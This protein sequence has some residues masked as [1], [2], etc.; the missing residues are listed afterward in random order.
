MN[1]NN[2]N[3]LLIPIHIDALAVGKKQP[4]NKR[5]KWTRLGADFSRV[6]APDGG[7]NYLLAGDTL[8]SLDDSRPT[9][10]T[11]VHLHFKLPKAFLHGKHD[12]DGE[13]E[14]PQI[15]N[16]WLIQRFSN[17]SSAYDAWLVKSDKLVENDRSQATPW[18]IFPSDSET[19]LEVKHIGENK[20]LTDKLNE[21]QDEAAEVKLTAIGQGDP[22]FSAHYPA[23]RSVLGFY[24]PLT[25]VSD[26][27]ELNYLVTGWFSAA[28]DDPLYLSSDDVDN[29]SIDVFKQ[30]IEENQIELIGESDSIPTR[31]LCHGLVRKLKW[32]G[33]SYNYFESDKPQAVFP[34]NSDHYAKQ[35]Q[36]AIGNNNIEALVSL[37]KMKC[38]DE[39]MLQ[40]STKENPIDESLLCAL[41]AGLL[42]QPITLNELQYEL[43]GRR[44]EGRQAGIK[45]SIQPN[46]EVSSASNETGQQNQ[47]LPNSL[48]TQLDKLN[49][50][51]N[52][53]NEFVIKYQDALTEVK[54]LWYL[55]TY[56]RS[57]AFSNDDA[58]LQKEYQQKENVYKRL[59]AEFKPR[60][61]QLSQQFKHISI[62]CE[63]AKSVLLKAIESNPAE[64]KYSL[65]TLSEQAY[66]QPTE[67]AIA[68]SGP[69][70]KFHN[71][72]QQP[73]D[74]KLL[75]RY[76]NQVITGVE[77]SPRGG[78]T[79]EVRTEQLLQYLGLDEKLI[80]KGMHRALL[81]EAIFIDDTNANKTAKLVG[82]DVEYL[83]DE[84]ITLLSP[85][86]QHEQAKNTNK[87]LG[88]VPDALIWQL[89]QG[90]PWN[91]LVL[92]WDVGWLPDKLNQVGS[93]LSSE[94]ICNSWAPAS[95]G[96]LVLSSSSS[97]EHQYQ[98]QSQSVSYQGQAIL[99]AST[100]NN[101]GERLKE[102]QSS[103]SL[104]SMLN[105][106]NTLVQ[107]LDG[108][109]DGLIK[110]TKAVKIPPLDFAR[111]EDSEGQ[112]LYLDSINTLLNHADSNIQP[113]EAVP[114]VADRPFLPIRSGYM[115][116]ERLCI[117]DA[118]GQVL[119][120]PKIDNTAKS[121][122]VAVTFQQASSKN[123]LHINLKPRMVAPSRLKF[124]VGST[125]EPSEKNDG[126]CGW[127]IP[128][129]LD[130]SLM[131]FSSLGEPLGA[132]QKKLAIDEDKA[133]YWLDTPGSVDIATSI[134]VEQMSTR[135]DS[136]VTDPE[137]RHFCHWLISLSSAE[138]E[139]FNDLLTAA[140]ASTVN[141]SP[142]SATAVSTLLGRPLALVCTQ[143]QLETAGQSP[144]D[145][146]LNIDSSSSGRS[147]ENY[148]ACINTYGVESVEWPIRLGDIHA[149]D[150]GLVG[151]FSMAS[152][153]NNHSSYS[154]FYPT[155]GLD[156]W[157]EWKYSKQE[158]TVNCQSPMK[159]TLL[160]DPQARVYATTGSQPRAHLELDRDSMQGSKH[161]QDFFFQVA[162]LVGVSDIPDMPRPSD[163]YGQWS[164]ACRPNVTQW[165]IDPN[166]REASTNN[167]FSADRPSINEG[168]LNLRVS[169]VKVE[170][171]WVMTPSVSSIPKD[172][173]HAIVPPDTPIQLSWKCVYA[174]SLEL[175]KVN[176][177][178]ISSIKK[179][180]K[181]ALEEK[182]K[183]TVKGN[184]VYRLVAYAEDGSSDHK[185]IQVSVS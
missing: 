14:F 92:G 42:S 76:S 99:T 48:Q 158:F 146:D 70:T 167:G 7:K 162:P 46:M 170:S 165:N 33:S 126:V 134:T 79:I 1:I 13:L 182:Y 107:G 102:L 161:A 66:Y 115:Q 54:R 132:I 144:H 119:K 37:L 103:D 160:M 174:N 83:A 159:L 122:D 98:S 116:I 173:T 61:E 55:Y 63:S 35:Y 155:W 81:A 32:Q 41:S 141:R 150:D 140:Q 78:E 128:N 148:N 157:D 111:W 24:D 169:R 181:G 106:L 149:P 52:Q 156:R 82:I 93:S 137:L 89:W 5:F 47:Q 9:L 166:L 131:I 154:P 138:G 108:F 110:R 109:N 27:A 145:L 34:I 40:T 153:T 51:Q 143:L 84:V 28:K 11:G 94:S 136:A 69:A 100:A 184:S 175:F 43:H 31:I 95:T 121:P 73:A 135:I 120:L 72:W 90:N 71:S 3:Q 177:D 21:I 57:A 59:L 118:F 29:A 185:D 123:A 65:T 178:E 96:D 26:N 62:A 12:G 147:G 112:S 25:G 67:P 74:N 180:D 88:I 50:Q 8:A 113:G 127:V 17:D 45:Y 142:E 68:I 23:C 129:M 85:R 16:R 164:W 168:Y 77:L 171:F 19:S 36:V 139:R 117:I 86:S 22:L 60:V 101:L 53:Y 179:W 30:F 49:R 80:C 87:L 64:V 124:T 2:D 172:K 91:P 18:L 151:I 58:A 10:E 4:N 104:V 176:D 6:Y 152:S 38:T 75:C 163:D 56:N 105:S 130:K 125:T 39:G 20:R 97:P 183:I 114:E 15:P 133:F 44:F